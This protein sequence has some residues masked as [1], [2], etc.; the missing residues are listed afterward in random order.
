M[1][2]IMD[3]AAHDR[4]KARTAS[5]YGGRDGVDIEG[6]LDIQTGKLKAL[7]RRHYL[8]TPTQTRAEDLVWIIRFFTLDAITALAYGEP[9]SY[10]DTNE[11]LFG[12]NE[13]VQEMT[14]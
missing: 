13:Q 4:L 6:G 8:S 5:G 1:L 7:I 3:T 12:F 2:T 11:D 10:L 9:F 14:K